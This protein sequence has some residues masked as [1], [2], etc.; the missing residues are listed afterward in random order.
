MRLALS[1]W[2]V[3]IACMVVM[4]APLAAPDPAELA[5][6]R[7]AAERQ[8]A[9]L[10]NRIQSLQKELDAR[11]AVRKEAADALKAS[12]VAISHTTRRLEELATQLKKAR[13]ELEEHE[14]QIQRQQST[15]AL[16][17]EELSDQLR[18]QYASGL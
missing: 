15:L 8:R 5:S 6:Q 14:K 3:T 18:R 1:K 9:D 16:R 17:R 12:E 4:G 2:C 13:A 7:S 10:R 11:E